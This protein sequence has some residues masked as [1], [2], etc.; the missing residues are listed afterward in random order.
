M[1]IPIQDIRPGTI[2]YRNGD[3]GPFRIVTVA[4]GWVML[5]RPKCMPFLAAVSTMT[6]PSK[7]D[8]QWSTKT[9]PAMAQDAA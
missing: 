1:A 2:C 9:P 3:D 5:R 7:R 6:R 4:E 8:D